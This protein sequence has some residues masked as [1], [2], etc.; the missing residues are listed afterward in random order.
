MSEEIQKQQP[1]QE[2]STNTT[3][4]IIE[5]AEAANKQA[6]ENI[7]KQEELLKR[8]EEIAAK[9]LLGGRAEAGTAPKVVDAEEEANKQAMSL[10]AG[11]GLNPFKNARKN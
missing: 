4:S 9:M 6:Q 1:T 5:R 10:L 11:T 2:A 8:Q 7:R 3:L